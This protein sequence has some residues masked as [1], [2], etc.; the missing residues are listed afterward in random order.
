M[1]PT[2]LARVGIVGAGFM[3][4]GIAQVS[5]AAGL[6]VVLVDRDQA[7]AA[8]GK[9][10]LDKRLGEARYLGGGDYSIADM[11]TWPWAKRSELLALRM[12][13]HP[14]LARW[15]AEIQARPAAKAT[16]AKEEQIRAQD[17]KAFQSATPD[18]LDRFFIRGKYA[19]T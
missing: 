19:R 1:P 17:G 8:A 13:E 14:N 10:G 7:T 15:V 16:D 9:D 6:E 2:K 12:D 11:A 3:G 4:A 5:A 18:Q